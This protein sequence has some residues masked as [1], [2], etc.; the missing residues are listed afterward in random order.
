M[1]HYAFLSNFIRR[2]IVDARFAGESEM[3]TVELFNVS[4]VTVSKVM[5]VCTK[6][7]KMS[8][9]RRSS[10]CKTMLAERDC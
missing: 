1:I 6:H 10:G 4:R 5:T 7:G 2:L 3:K 9:A 8:S